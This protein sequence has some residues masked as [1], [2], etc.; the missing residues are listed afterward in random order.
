M[1]CL[2]TDPLGR[3][4]AARPFIS[5]VLARAEQLLTQLLA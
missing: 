4:A 3:L 5:E 1:F 2:K